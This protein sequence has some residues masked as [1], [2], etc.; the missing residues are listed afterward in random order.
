MPARTLLVCPAAALS[1][2]SPVVTAAP[3]PVRPLALRERRVPARLVR[4]PASSHGRWTPSD[5]AHFFLEGLDWWRRW[6]EPE[7]R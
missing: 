7:Q 3:Q 4:Y 6:L 2:G 1:L 5:R